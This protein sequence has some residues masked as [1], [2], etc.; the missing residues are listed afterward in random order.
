VVYGVVESNVRGL[1]GIPAQPSRR[2]KSGGPIN[3]GAVINGHDGDH[4]R[5]PIDDP[6]TPPARTVKSFKLTAKGLPHPVRV[7]GDRTVNELNGR[8]GDLLGKVR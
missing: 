3:I 8:R 1:A 7:V 4:V 2:G 5:D 6:K